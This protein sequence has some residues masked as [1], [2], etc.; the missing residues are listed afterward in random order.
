MPHGATTDRGSRTGAAHAWP[1]L[2]P[3]TP[4]LFLFDVGYRFARPVPMDLSSAQDATTT[5]G[6]A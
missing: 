5:G 1:A 2:V 6:R 4:C 3:A